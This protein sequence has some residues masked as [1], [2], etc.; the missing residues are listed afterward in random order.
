MSDIIWYYLI[1][2]D[3]MIYDPLRGMG[4]DYNMVSARA[5]Q[6]DSRLELPN[7]VDVKLAVL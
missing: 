1:T 7:D 3:H 2:E 5:Y 6:G 4:I